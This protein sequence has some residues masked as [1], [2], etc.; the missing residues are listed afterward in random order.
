MIGD[1]LNVRWL[2]LK[3]L[4]QDPSLIGEIHAYLGEDIL[5]DQPL[6]AALEEAHTLLAREGLDAGRLKDEIV[7][8]L[9]LRAEKICKDAVIH[10]KSGYHALDRRLDR[11]LTSRWSGYPIMLALLAWSSG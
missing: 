5:M 1:R 8:S 2:S 9:M 3:L 11:I 6:A 10:E 7:S 4:D